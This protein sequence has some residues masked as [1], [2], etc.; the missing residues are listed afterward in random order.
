[1]SNADGDAV[2]EFVFTQEQLD[3]GDDLLTVWKW[4]NDNTDKADGLVGMSEFHELTLVRDGVMDAIGEAHKLSG[5]KDKPD[6]VLAYARRD[7]MSDVSRTLCGL[8]NRSPTQLRTGSSSYTSWATEIHTHESKPKVR[9]EDQQQGVR[10][11]VRKDI[12]DLWNIDA[13]GKQPLPSDVAS[14]VFRDWVEATIERADWVE[15]V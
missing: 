10:I 3:E 13:D 8:G 6:Y 1:L 4:L 7:N 2:Q 9:L 5:K 12:S 14:V 11:E 15:A